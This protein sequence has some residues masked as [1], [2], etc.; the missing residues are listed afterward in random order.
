M[1]STW[2]DFLY[3]DRQIYL[4]AGLL[5]KNVRPIILTPISDTDPT[6]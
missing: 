5:V 6:V 2:N 1:I 3:F 4:Y